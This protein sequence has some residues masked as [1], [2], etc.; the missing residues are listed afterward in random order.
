MLVNRV[1]DLVVKVS[2]S[3][4]D[5]VGSTRRYEPSKHYMRGPGPKSAEAARR[6]NSRATTAR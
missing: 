5:S 3:V 1:I 2:R 4:V 6:S